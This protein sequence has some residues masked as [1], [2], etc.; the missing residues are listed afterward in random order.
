MPH[1]KPDR[2]FSLVRME[3]L[4]DKS[5]S[6]KDVLDILVSSGRSR[7]LMTLNT[8]DLP[9][10]NI[11]S[12]LAVIAKAV[13]CGTERAMVIDLLTMVLGTRFFTSEIPAALSIFRSSK[14]EED[15]IKFIQNLVD[16]IHQLLLC[17]PHSII[18]AFGHIVIVKKITDDMLLTTSSSN[19]Q[20]VQSLS[21][22]VLNLKDTAQERMTAYGKG[23]SKTRTERQPPPDD[24][25]RIPI[26]PGTS[27]IFLNSR[28]VYLRENKA[29]GG[30]ENLDHYLDVQFRLYREDCISPLRDGIIEYVRAVN[31]GQ[32][33]GR[34]QDGKLYKKIVAI[35][36]EST[37]E[38]E[39]YVIKMD[40]EHS[41]KIN[42]MSSQRLIYGSLVCL[43]ADNFHNMHFAVVSQSD[44]RDLQKKREF[45][46]VCPGN[47]I[48]PFERNMTMVESSAYF[49]AYRHVLAGLQNI[50]KG[51][52]PFEK[53]IVECRKDVDPPF[54]L[55]KRETAYDL[56]P[57]LSN[58]LI[59]KGK[60]NVNN[61][62]RKRCMVGTLLPKSV[63]PH[64][65]KL[66]LDQSQFE[67]FHASL[68]QEFVLIQGPPGTGKTHVGL[69]IAKTLLHNKTAWA[70]DETEIKD[71]KKI[72]RKCPMLVVCFTNH[73]LDQF[74][75]GIVKFLDPSAKSSWKND[76]VRVGGRSENTTIEEFSLKKR[77]YLFRGRGVDEKGIFDSVQNLQLGIANIKYRLGKCK[78]VILDA[79]H[80]K[81][82]MSEH[83][84]KAFKE[85]RFGSQQL[86]KWLG[87]DEIS[88]M[89][90]AQ[91][92]YFQRLETFQRRQMYPE[93]QKEEE[94][95][96]VKTDAEIF[97]DDRRI[98][99]DTVAS[100]KVE[101]DIGLDMK[102]SI[103]SILQNGENV[104]ETPHMDDLFKALITKEITKTFDELK[105]EDIMTDREAGF[106][107]SWNLEKLSS[108]DID[109]RWRLYRYW[110]RK[111]MAVEEEKLS[112]L[113][114]EL[115]ETL[116]DYQKE[117]KRR[118][119]MILK[120]A[121]V[122]AMT[123]S[124]AARYHDVLKDIGPRIVIVEEAAEVL[125]THI[126]TALSPKCEHL[127]LIGDHKQL[128]PKPSVYRLEQEYNLGVSLFERMLNNG[129][130]NHCLQRQ[131]RMRPEISTLV[132]DI[133]PVLE[134]NENVFKYD[135]VMG[136]EKDVFFISHNSQEDFGGDTRSFSNAHEA[137]YVVALCRHL[138]KQGYAP[139]QI[140]I[141]AAYS[142]QMFCIRNKMPRNEFE[143]VRAVAIDNFQGE[144][145][146]IILLSLVRSNKTGNIGFLK[147]E[148]RVCVALSRA[149]IGLYVIGNFSMF[150]A[151][152]PLWEKIIKKTKSAHQFG[153]ALPV[154]C[155]NHPHTHNL[156]T[157][158]TDFDKL[159]DGGCDRKCDFRLPCGHVCRLFCH[160]TDK[161]HTE[162]KCK[163][164]CTKTCSKGHPCKRRCHYNED[165]KCPVR[166]EKVLPCG[167]RATM[168]C[169][170]SAKDYK[171][172]VIVER[173]LACGHETKMEC[174]VDPVK[175][176]C[177]QIVTRKLP[178]CQHTAE[179][180]CHIDP[181]TYQC[182]KI[183]TRELYACKHT[184]E[185]ECWVDPTKY[186]CTVEVIKIREDCGHN[187]DVVCSRYSPSYE[188]NNQC[189]VVISKNFSECQHQVEV[190]CYVDISEMKCRTIVRKQ[191]KC[192]H[193]A[194]L[195]CWSYK[196][197]KC[198]QKC[199]RK[200]SIG[201]KC[202]KTCH[203]PENCICKHLVDKA[204][205]Y[206]CHIQQ[207]MCHIDPSSIDCPEIVSKELPRCG[208]VM[209]M[210][211]HEDPNQMKCMKI[212]SKRIK[213]CGHS[214]EMECFLDPSEFK[215]TSLVEKVL[216]KCGHIKTLKCSADPNNHKCDQNV[217]K[218]LPCGHETNMK[219]CQYPDK[220]TP[221]HVKVKVSRQIC[222]HTVEVECSKK[223]S[224]DPNK[225]KCYKMTKK[226][227]MCG[228]ERSVECWKSDLKQQCHQKCSV[229]LLC[230]H[231]CG[232]E[233]RKCSKSLF[234][235]NCQ[236]LCYKAL[237]CGHTC[238]KKKC[239]SCQP[240]EKQCE[241]YCSHR[242]CAH[243]CGSECGP[244]K[245]KCSLECP[246][247]KC[248]RLCYEQCDRPRC[249]RRCPQ[250]LNCQHRCVGFCGD[251]CPTNCVKCGITDIQEVDVLKST[252][253]NVRIVRLVDCGH[254][255]ESSYL[256]HV[257]DGVTNPL[258]IF[259]CPK[260][261]E[262]VRW[263]PR[264]ANVLKM[265]REA[266]DSVKGM[267]K[268]QDAQGCILKKSF[269]KEQ[270]DI[271]DVNVYIKRFHTFLYIWEKL[272][273]RTTE[274]ELI[275]QWAVSFTKM[276]GQLL[277][278]SPHNILMTLEQV[279]SI[280]RNMCKLSAVWLLFISSQ[281]RNKSSDIQV[282]STTTVQPTCDKTII[283]V[284]EEQNN[285]SEAEVFIRKTDTFSQS[286][287][288]KVRQLLHPFLTNTSESTI[289]LNFPI[290]AAFGIHKD[291]WIICDKGHPRPSNIWSKT[292]SKCSRKNDFKQ[293]E[294]KIDDL[295]GE[296]GCGRSH[297]HTRGIGSDPK[298]PTGRGRARRRSRGRGNHDGSVKF[299]QSRG[300]GEFKAK[301]DGRNERHLRDEGDEKDKQVRGIGHGRG[302]N[303]K[304]GNV[305]EKKGNMG[306]DDRKAISKG[307][308][309]NWGRENKER[310][311]VG[312]KGKGD[313]GRDKKWGHGCDT[314]VQRHD[315]EESD[316]GGHNGKP[317]IGH[318][319]R[320][321]RKQ[322]SG[323]T[324]PI[325]DSNDRV[326]SGESISERGKNR[327]D[328]TQRRRGR[329]RC[330]GSTR[331]LREV[332]CNDSGDD[333]GG[334]SNDT[335]DKDHQKRGKCGRRSGVS[336]E[337]SG[338]M[339][340]Q[341]K[342]V[343][344]NGESNRG[345]GNGERGRGIRG[346]RG[347]GSRGGRGRGRRG[348]GGRSN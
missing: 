260:C 244:C 58:Q 93:I 233:C 59:F 91:T 71:K 136:I 5:H 94:L 293:R 14:C 152:S 191:W 348:Q 292:C 268:L 251:P 254:E 281:W 311:V 204:M 225:L 339:N 149:K 153:N 1:G 165:C 321:G 167:H 52:L 41:S 298:M 147:R 67:A 196:E 74:M 214:K 334:L 29:V 291:D 43:S 237:I 159:P 53:H 346:G 218:K 105:S 176:Q 296:D 211:C 217:R 246:H 46:V 101:K 273:D 276:F 45:S 332:G 197:A 72:E 36:K 210:P 79:S 161:E 83:T 258:D 242:H 312:S 60:S 111:F 198:E 269:P 266:I 172:E 173:S 154:V 265:Q 21:D 88:W 249:N 66:H 224:I 322:S 146:D 253:D 144:E 184:A 49:E 6:S 139:N 286:S 122:I 341:R 201:H 229:T 270:G 337:E 134:D 142:G 301:S 18:D 200:C 27:D 17:L 199:L 300:E 279:H 31:A 156:M 131:H 309:H 63:W 313:E 16:L 316:D 55:A 65:E 145:T 68:T 303:G 285:I 119:A 327:E 227:L 238:H 24:F 338:A 28:R 148:N 133:Y 263:H 284:L 342:E 103:S 240:C 35:S 275:L 307:D 78:S 15:T 73:A 329:V 47:D 40:K 252:S 302:R 76:I 86:F 84:Y 158:A 220:S 140:T 169:H 11:A 333:K 174:H 310:N 10:V 347:R 150:K 3:S 308:G 48:L 12:W 259:R 135:H 110:V 183:V 190:A 187:Y 89:Q 130:E 314:G 164:I 189:T 262:I 126:V 44:R 125:E 75:E 344:N 121:T 50:G 56:Q 107:S 22:S 320:Q 185:L 116:K 115:S 325:R 193:T 239:G 236:N 305:G 98:E 85:K 61:N 112:T 38:G 241:N 109:N 26:L 306:V 232:G 42:W 290:L 118:D 216:P 177:K 215:C 127:I 288:Q 137:C 64:A 30:Y 178:G 297:N 255:F 221:C 141:L 294:L 166:M 195:Q 323:G 345:R 51:E 267:I 282:E 208:H 335:G 235:E 299:V 188:R 92:A 128:E 9:P 95:L 82:V 124:G 54:Y 114:R 179:L 77:R 57:I 243:A 182:R 231:L 151:A 20:H 13:R 317:R 336:K 129:I 226:E 87:A 228:H 287:L 37:I 318:G 175:Y 117:K 315:C 8:P 143:G 62:S 295:R 81:P 168:K 192:S 33:I 113:E 80:L 248:S 108:Y 257:A 186:K 331:S 97:E 203:Y 70:T 181:I 96:D 256:D 223:T 123:T 234:H 170:I 100:L 206:C 104:S 264:Y 120:S 202:Y 39:Q 328:G 32:N 324:I 23:R 155:Q 278:S 25:R 19:R 274:V 212:V 213:L 90:K 34:L 69:A 222:S 272:H 245:D 283:N 2:L 205:P 250:I 343:G 209:E 326:A 247:H 106:S 171:C 180:E 340:T 277:N 102:Y 280:N 157:S 289:A 4:L 138:M 261:Q 194:D 330:R 319:R 99:D 271:Q 304:M 162:Y 230:G 7:A 207:I 163:E 219:C 160:P 132:R